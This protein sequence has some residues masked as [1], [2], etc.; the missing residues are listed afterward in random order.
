MRN[1]DLYIYNTN[2]GKIETYHG[3]VRFGTQDNDGNLDKMIATVTYP[4]MYNNNKH[5]RSTFVDPHS[6]NVYVLN[7]EY[8]IWTIEST[9]KDIYNKIKDFINVQMDM[10]ISL[11]QE[12]INDCISVRNRANDVLNFE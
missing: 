9:P 3:I 6:D 7:D 5:Y 10:E 1:V 11:L 12:K 2:T 8:R 4:I